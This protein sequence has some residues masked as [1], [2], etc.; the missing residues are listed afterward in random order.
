MPEHALALAL[1]SAAGV[2]I[3]APSAN[4]SG[5][6]S[7]TEAAHVAAEFPKGIA[8]I[9]DGGRCRVGLESTVVDL[10]GDRPALL[11]PGGLA[12]D[13]ILTELGPLAGA[14]AGPPRAPGQLARHYAPGRPVRLDALQAEPGEVLLGFGPTAR[15]A[16]CNLSPAGDLVEAAANL[17][18]MLRALDRPDVR[19]IAVSPIPNAGLGRAINDRLRRAATPPAASEGEDW[20]EGRIGALPCVL[21]DPDEDTAVLP[22]PLP[23]AN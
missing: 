16:A 13:A 23:P 5:A 18:A 15:N 14:A 4:R 2:P 1:I 21:P 11:R 17:F 19:A 6:I 8:M 10:T 12:T 9:L 3:A 20:D 22:G 7:P